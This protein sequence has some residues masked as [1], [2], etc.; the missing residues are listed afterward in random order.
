MTGMGSVAVLM[1]GSVTDAQRMQHWLDRGTNVAVFSI[2]NNLAQHVTLL[3]F[4]RFEGND[5]FRQ[6]E[7]TP[8]LTSGLPYVPPGESIKIRVAVLPHTGPWR[9][10]V[11]YL[12]DPAAEGYFGVVK[13]GIRR[14]ASIRRSEQARTIVSD[15]VIP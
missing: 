9:I 12:P 3:Q 13:R 15:W 1:R 10:Q 6:I 7:D 4:A 5:G 14:I 2:T 8:I 11:D